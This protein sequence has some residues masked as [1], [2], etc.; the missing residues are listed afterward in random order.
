MPIEYAGISAYVEERWWIVDFQEALRIL[1][2]VPIQ[3]AA[4]KFADLGQFLLG[5]LVRM[6]GLDRPRRRGGQVASLEFGKGSAKHIPGR[7]ELAQ[8][9]SGET[10]AEGG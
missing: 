6:L 4:A 2:F 1:R 3:E 10:R 8:Q 5:I 9:F 7:S